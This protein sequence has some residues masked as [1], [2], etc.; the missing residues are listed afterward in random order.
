VT[1][2]IPPLCGTTDFFAAAVGTALAS[3]LV[4]G[5]LGTTIQRELSRSPA[6]SGELLEHLNLDNVAFISNDFLQKRLSGTTAT[7]DQITEAVRINTQARLRALRICFFVLAGL[8]ALAFLPA[9]AL[10][11]YD[12]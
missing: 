1:D 11:D 4:I 3:A 9:A 10:P 8:A 12:S 2:E 7:A 6:V 5:V